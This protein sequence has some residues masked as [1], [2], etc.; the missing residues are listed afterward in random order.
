[1]NKDNMNQLSSKNGGN[2]RHRSLTAAVANPTGR[3]DPTK[4]IF[5]G[6]PTQSYDN[7]MD[8]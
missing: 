2:S 7:C 4:S 6:I 1:M 3:R 5:A 8:R